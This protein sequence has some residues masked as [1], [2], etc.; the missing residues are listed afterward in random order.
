MQCTCALPVGL[1]VYTC[2]RCQARHTQRRFMNRADI[3]MPSLSNAPY[4]TRVYFTGREDSVYFTERGGGQCVTD[5]DA[6]NHRADRALLIALV[7]GLPPR[8]PHQLPKLDTPQA[9]HC[10]TRKPKTR[11]AREHPY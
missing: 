3:Q 10:S 11:N 9:V 5:N 6:V 2:L 4:I 1:C 8:T 7:Q